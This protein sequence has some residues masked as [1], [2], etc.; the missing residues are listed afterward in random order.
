MDRSFLSQAP[1]I[2]ASRSFICVRVPSYEDESEMRFCRDLF[3][4]RSGDAEN[5]TFAIL[6]PDGKTPLVRSGRS[7]RR[8]FDGPEDMAKAMVRIA[9]RYRAAG[10]P[11]ALPVA[12]DVRLGLT[13]AAS[14]GL[15]LVVV[16]AKEPA[17]LEAKVAA[18]T[19]RDEFIGRFTF[20]V[21]AG[22]KDCKGIDGVSGKEGIF[23]VEPD[24]FGQ[25]GRAVGRVEADSVDRLEEAMRAALRAHKAPA[26]DTRSHRLAGIESGVFYEPKLPVTDPEEA[27]ARNRTKRAMQRRDR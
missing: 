2:A 23:F 1:V 4:G 8:L 5:T 18:L 25:Q 6:S 9:A 17:A 15:P 10:E 20:A 27:G 12:G 26:K 14:D 7:A 24:A 21:A 3:L 22:A 19:W 16:L 11:Q 13:I